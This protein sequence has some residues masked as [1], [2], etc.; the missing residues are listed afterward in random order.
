[1]VGCELGG[2]VKN[3]IAL[4][5]G[6]AEG[7][8]FGDNTRASLITRGLAETARLGMALGAEL[9]TFAGLA[10]LGD[11]VATCSSPLSRNRTFGEKLGQGMS[12]EEVQQST[13]Q[14]AEGVKSCRS[15]LDLAR[16]HDI[17]VPITEAVV[18]V[19]HEGQSPGAMVKAMMTREAKPE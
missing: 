5:C 7:L 19:C 9:T 11:L 8:G 18:Q 6:I 3:V 12:L 15:V 2:A 16:A 13:R 1:V 14:T 4:A 10:G 17:Y